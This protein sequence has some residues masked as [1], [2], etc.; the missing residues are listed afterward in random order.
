M[1]EKRTLTN[2][3]KNMLWALAIV[4][5]CAAMVCFL[6]LPQR[7][8]QQALADDVEALAAQRVETENTIARL[9]EAKQAYEDAQVVYEAAQSAFM[10]PMKP[11]ELDATVTQMLIDSGFAPQSLSVSALAQ[12][13]VAP[14][15][16]QSLTG[17]GGAGDASTAA[18]AA[19][20]AYAYTVNATVSGTLENFYAL[21]DKV[22][23]RQ[24]MKIARWTWADGAFSVT[25]KAY[26]F[27]EGAYRAEE[28]AD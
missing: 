21:M 9:P 3:E 1:I 11:D 20:T 15:A 2:K 16:P 14:Y 8:E 5:A 10:Q 19:G 6:I 13:A 12:E 24:G 22:A 4:A 28:E 26:V 25:L 17:A 23:A 7:A 18:G 27:V